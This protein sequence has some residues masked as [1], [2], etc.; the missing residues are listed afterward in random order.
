M[1]GLKLRGEEV[2]TAMKRILKRKAAEVRG[3]VAIS[4]NI[5]FPKR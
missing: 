2:G 1:C 3:R 4:S 5:F